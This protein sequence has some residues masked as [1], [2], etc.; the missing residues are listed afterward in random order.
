MDIIDIKTI[1]P[2]ILFGI[3]NEK[4]RLECDSMDHLINRFEID[5]LE[6]KE[7][8]N[9]LGCYYDEDTNQLKLK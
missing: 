5:P 7:K 9:D 8:M 1:E 3:L 4:L 2:A 6:L